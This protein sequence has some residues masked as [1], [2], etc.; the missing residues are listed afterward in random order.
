MKSH[1]M[2]K[3]CPDCGHATEY[4]AD[5]CPHCACWLDSESAASLAVTFLII[6]SL[7]FYGTLWVLNREEPAPQPAPAAAGVVK[8]H[9]FSTDF[10]S[11]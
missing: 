3:P 1:S 2:K 9:R 7:A 5:E 10:A 11:A 4:W 6:Y 8:D